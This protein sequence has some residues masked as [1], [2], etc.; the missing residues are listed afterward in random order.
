[1]NKTRHALRIAVAG[2]ALGATLLTSGGVAS[3]HHVPPGPWPSGH[4]R[5]Q[6]I[7]AFR[8]GMGM[9]LS[10]RNCISSS[11]RIGQRISWNLGYHTRF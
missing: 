10:L 3:A 4:E 8:Y 6:E 9:G 5:C 1:M 2:L 11:P 7:N